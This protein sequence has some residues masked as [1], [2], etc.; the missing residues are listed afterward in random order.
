M[1]VGD[2]CKRDEAK[3]LE[4]QPGATGVAVGTE[5]RGRAEETRSDT[6]TDTQTASDQPAR[7]DTAMAKRPAELES[8]ASQGSVTGS[9]N[10]AL[11]D[12]KV[13]GSAIPNT[14]FGSPIV[15]RDEG[16][17][18]GI[19]EAQCSTFS[20]ANYKIKV[21]GE[22]FG[23]EWLVIVSDCASRKGLA[24]CC[25]ARLLLDPSE[26]PREG[27]GYDR[28]GEL[29]IG[30]RSYTGEQHYRYAPASRTKW[31]CELTFYVADRFD[32]HVKG[33]RILSDQCPDVAAKIDLEALERLAAK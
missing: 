14:L 16:S 2:G 30:G 8:G 10:D 29:Q 18:E 17:S 25:G 21:P 19:T 5:P 11:I 20:A 28:Y 3:G 4:N 9:G 26:D 22:L 7:G 1:W 23:P 32:V 15:E 33:E 12:P 31:M 6:N 27:G 24:N 13:L